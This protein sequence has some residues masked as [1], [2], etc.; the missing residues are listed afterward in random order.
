MDE[1][2]T[3]PKTQ[4]VDAIL[5]GIKNAHK[6]NKKWT[7][8]SWLSMAPEYMINIFIGQSL[9]KLKPMPH[10]WFEINIDDLA[11]S[12]NPIDIKKFKKDI[13]RNGKNL[14]KNQKEKIDI[15]LDDKENSKV[16]IEVKN[17][18]C[19]YGNGIDKDIRRICNAL[20]H[21]SSLE[22]GIFAFFANDDKRNILDVVK[23]IKIQAK[24]V[25]SQ[26]SINFKTKLD[27]ITDAENDWSC[28]AVCFILKRK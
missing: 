19:K 11:E 1:M 16:I 4:V 2:D 3:F 23:D 20:T 21:Q 10:I 25:A 5:T 8:G 28:A 24:D 9:E 17:G 12:S 6:K 15:V 7:G 18:V 27:V 13:T 22:Y 14:E 26:Y